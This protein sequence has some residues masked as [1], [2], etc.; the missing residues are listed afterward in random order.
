V[1]RPIFADHECS[2]RNVM[3]LRDEPHYQ[4]AS[5]ELADWLE[6]QGKDIWWG[7]DG[8]PHLTQW[9]NFPCPADVLAAE[10]RRINRPLLIRDPN[11]GPEARGQQVT[12][13]ELDQLAT[14]FW[15]GFPRTGPGPRPVW[16]DDRAFYL[17]WPNR[18]DEWML[19]E[20][21]ETTEEERQE[22]ARL[23]RGTG[24]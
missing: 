13:Q 22:A 16:I 4:I 7:V 15:S 6:R 19:L 3:S 2:R 1:D 17:A 12:A 20:D 9:I 24:A 18:E 21:S 10:L 11:K 8:D 14:R 23:A 5:S